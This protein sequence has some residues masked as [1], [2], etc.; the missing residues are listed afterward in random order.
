MDENKNIG[1]YRI[2]V[3]WIDI[4]YLRLDQ[5]EDGFCAL[6]WIGNGIIF[7]EYFFIFISMTRSWAIKEICTKR[8]TTQFNVTCSSFFTMC[9][10]NGWNTPGFSFSFICFHFF[11]RNFLIDDGVFCIPDLFIFPFGQKGI[12]LRYSIVNYHEKI[13]AR[14]VTSF[15]KCFG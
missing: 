7:L 14:P 12:C 4:Y 13:G 9:K 5:V 1:L 10:Y 15:G 6:L 8:K 3:A 11:P 2:S